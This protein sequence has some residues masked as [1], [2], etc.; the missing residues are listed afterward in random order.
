MVR[1][2][3][4]YGTAHDRTGQIARARV[5]LRNGGNPD[6]LEDELRQYALAHLASYKVPEAFEFVQTL[7]KTASGKILH[8]L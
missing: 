7:P 8:R 1:E 5:V 4:V 2:A 6:A 3:A